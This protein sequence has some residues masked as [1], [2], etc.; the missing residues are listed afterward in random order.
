M[1]KG[2]SGGMQTTQQAYQPI[3]PFLQGGW[4]A[5]QNLFNQNPL[6]YYPGQTLAQSGR[7]E[8]T[9]AYQGLYNQGANYSGFA[10][11]SYDAYGR[12]VGG[13]ANV[14]NSPAYS[15]LQGFAGGT[16]PGQMDLAQ[17]QQQ[18]GGWG[19]Q[20][21]ADVGQYAPQAA[22]YGAQAAYGNNLGLSQLGASASG[23][24]LNSNPNFTQSVLDPIT[25]AYQTATAPSASA[26]ASAAGRYGS[27]AQAGMVNT[28][29]Q[30]L[31]RGLRDAAAV[32][33]SRERQLQ[34][35]AAQQY[36][37]LVNQGY[38]LGIRGATAGA[39]IANAAG[40]QNLAYQQAVQDAIR[41]QMGAQQYGL[42]GLQSG[43]QSGN[44]LTAEALRQFPQLAQTMF[45]GPQAQIQGAQGVTGQEQAQIADQMARYYGEQQAPYNTLAAYMKNL[46]Q[47]T[48]GSIEQQP[49]YT[50]DLANILGAGV[51][52]TGIGR[53]LGLFGSGASGL[54]GLGSLFGGGTAAATLPG[55]LGSTTALPAIAAAA[56]AAWIVCTELMRQGR[57]PKRRWAAGLAPFA[58]YPERTKAGYYTWA[59]PAVRHLRK[60]P[61]SWRS[62][63]L[64]AIANW[65]SENI[66]AK[67]GVRGARWRLRGALVTAVGYPFCAALG[68]FVQPQDWQQ[69]YRG[70]HV[71]GA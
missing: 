39:N 58:A 17:L 22:G 70:E 60:H 55:A 16:T 41:Q 45:A 29:E 67:R 23:Q 31:A 14:Q 4:T 42:S 9:G 34:D 33:Y 65:R 12:I 52:L 43:F 69:V 63:A 3:T 26:A 56:P 57:M 71:P 53:N 49:Q 13:G 62:R 32:N 28:N 36:G 15:G 25:H 40:G 59:I 8:T 35:Q 51:G 68:W 47:Q 46:G 48:G 24:Y 5:A 54:G 18:L 11:P 7:P 2:S 1:P 50:N 64:C 37:S 10:Q 66:A 20:Y 6:S 61:C 19:Q 21:A 38:D 30:N 27:G 44:Q